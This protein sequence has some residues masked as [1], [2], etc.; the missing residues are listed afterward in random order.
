MQNEAFLPFS[1]GVKKKNVCY[2]AFFGFKALFVDFSGLTL[3]L[4]HQK[5]CV[6]MWRRGAG[7]GG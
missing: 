5:L 1:F 2:G 3:D 6:C 7:R 4:Q